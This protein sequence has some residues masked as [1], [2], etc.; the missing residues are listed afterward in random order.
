[1]EENEENKVTET[2]EDKKPAAKKSPVAKKEEK[3]GTIKVRAK[4]NTQLYDPVS[5]TLY[6]DANEGKEVDEYNQFVVSNLNKGK[7]IKVK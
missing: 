5:K 2:Q 4:D 6:S 3:S 1:M 7:L